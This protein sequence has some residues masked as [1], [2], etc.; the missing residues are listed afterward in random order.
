M[1]NYCLVFLFYFYSASLLAK[2]DSP[3]QN[4]AAELD[5]WCQIAPQNDGFSDIDSAELQLPEDFA[6]QS[7]QAFADSLS[8]KRQDQ[9]QLAGNVVLVGKQQRIRAEKAAINQKTGILELEQNV[10]MRSA[11]I[12]LSGDSA[13]YNRNN[14]DITFTNAKYSLQSS[15]GNGTADG[16]Y[17]LKPKVTLLKNAAYT[18]CDM[19]N[20]DWH[21]R[22]S[23]IILDQNKGFGSAT[24]IRLAVGKVPVFYFPYLNFPIDDRRKSGLLFPTIGQSD[25]NGFEYTQPVYW[26]IHPM[27]DATFS[28]RSLSKRSLQL[29]ANLR[30]LNSYGSY[31]FTN[32]QLDDSLLQKNRQLD[33][34]V[35]RGKRGNWHSAAHFARVSD[36]DYLNELDSSLNMGRLQV[37]HSW[38]K[39]GYQGQNWQHLLGVDNYQTLDKSIAKN[40]TA[41]QRMP[42]LDS[43]ARYRKSG[44]EFIYHS[45]LTSFDHAQR[46][47]GNRYNFVPKIRWRNAN[48]AYSSVFEV[49]H[50]YTYYQL[51]DGQQ[52]AENSLS[53]FSFDNKLALERNGLDYLQTLEPRLYLLYVPYVKQ[54]HLPLY[55]TAHVDFSYEYLFASNRFSGHDRQGD[56]KQ[57]TLG[58]SHGVYS[59]QNGREILKSR[60]AQAF[61][62]EKLKVGLTDAA[63]SQRRYSDIA[64]DSKYNI[65]QNLNLSGRWQ[66]NPGISKFM[67]QRYQL[68]F[69]RQ[70]QMMAVAFTKA[71]YSY[72]QSELLFATALDSRWQLVGRWL[73]DIYNSQTLE[74]FA[75][76]SYQSCCWA[77]NLHGK[78]RLKVAKY[79]NEIYLQFTLKGLGS[80]GKDGAQVLR[81]TLHGYQ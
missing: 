60:L 27:A 68:A 22:A 33:A 42:Y 31:E 59:Q 43:S 12:S 10:L 81:K 20:P 41:Y 1:R 18:S 77:V 55:D 2:A 23:K 25:S 46:P 17:S 30:L 61:Y 32:E 69:S 40:A 39:L 47:A 79:H 51:R 52:N 29:I 34:F 5:K 54:R 70:Q 35:H 19:P 16:I 50:K 75:G 74:T 3:W 80:V 8:Y 4:E 62:A 36:N 63:P 66:Y 53:I 65:N 11:D 78:R 58:L 45:Q 76:V 67:R 38:A 28:A 13:S 7:M 49:A 26:N 48:M 64:L 57:A 44:V 24:H 14:K 21:L 37:I 9:L 6:A 73:Y 56:A 15:R 72:E 71:H